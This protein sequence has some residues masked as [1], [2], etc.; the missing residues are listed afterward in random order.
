M[1]EV[2]GSNVSHVKDYRNSGYG[3]TQSL[4]II[5]AV[6]TSIKPQ[7]ILAN[8]DPTMIHALIHAC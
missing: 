1:M 5:T 7:H 8:S 6:P 4:H 2:L 3:F